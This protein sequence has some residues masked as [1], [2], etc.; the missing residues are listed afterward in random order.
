MGSPRCLR[1]FSK[2]R[3]NMSS[4]FTD[5][6]EHWRSKTEG[7]GCGCYGNGVLPVPPCHLQG[8]SG[9]LCWGGAPCGFCCNSSQGAI[10]RQ[11]STVHRISR[12][13][14]SMVSY[15][16]F[17]E[18]WRG[19]CVGVVAAMKLCLAAAV[20]CCQLMLPSLPLS[21]ATGGG[22]QVPHVSR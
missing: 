4:L 7:E 21:S 19:E 11:Y 6:N 5:V 20:I 17:S 1:G 13:K 12:Y 3:Q 9:S 18:M 22:E 16:Q 8:H 15:S 14:T 10:D 2:W